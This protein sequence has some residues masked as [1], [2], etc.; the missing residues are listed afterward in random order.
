MDTY[1]D[2]EDLN[3]HFDLDI[4][5]SHQ[6]FEYGTGFVCVCVFFFFFFFF[7]VVVE[8]LNP[9]YVHDLEES[10]PNISQATTAFTPSHK[11]WL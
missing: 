9:Y 8:D 10:K 3:P 6:T 7:V 11:V 4:E 5:E 1:T 2:A